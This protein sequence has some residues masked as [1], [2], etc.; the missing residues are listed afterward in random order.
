MLVKHLKGTVIQSAIN[1]IVKTW[2]RS[3]SKRYNIN[4]TIV[5]ASSPRSGSTWLTEIIGS[6]PG[7]PIINE[8]LY[9]E[10][11]PE[12]T[13][14]GFTTSA[15]YVSAYEDDPIKQGYLHQIFTG[16]NLS[17]NL[18]S[19]EHFHPAQYLG[20]RGFL[21]KF[22]HANMLLYWALRQFPLRAVFTIRHPCAVVSSQLRHPG[23]NYAH[24]SNRDWPNTLEKIVPSNLA[25]DYPHLVEIYRRVKTKEEGL[26]FIWA[27]QNYIP[28]S[29]PKP[30]PWC[31]TVY[32]RLV[33]EGQREVER[34]FQFLGEPVPREA[35]KRLKIP[36]TTTKAD[37]NIMNGMNQLSGW[38]DKLTPHQIDTIL[39]VV[40][41]VGIDFYSDAL[42]PDY[43]KLLAYGLENS[44]YER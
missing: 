41:Q 10:K 2:G 1:P 35:Y 12:C 33:V 24:K 13:K 43:Q 34:L 36:S 29:Q 11:N 30:H 42:E 14:Y 18:A 4:N 8:P 31:L 15:P 21:V 27:M 38:K 28:L 6:L 17:T 5:I 44:V 32:E 19:L 25:I 16:A 39:N 20:F 26:A 23:W 7:Y 22:C 9:R 3:N 40:H 37:S